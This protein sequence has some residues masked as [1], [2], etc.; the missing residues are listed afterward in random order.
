MTII[1]TVPI[2]A[3]QNC[4][5]QT[6]DGQKVMHAVGCYCE[7]CAPFIGMAADRHAR[8]ELIAGVMMGVVSIPTS[9]YGPR[10]GRG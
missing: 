2:V 4:G 1:I 9:D 7:T 5:T 3:C 8:N 10:S 6:S